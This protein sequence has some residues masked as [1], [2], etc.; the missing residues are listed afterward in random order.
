M[1][2]ETHTRFAKLQRLRELFRAASI[3]RTAIRVAVC[4]DAASQQ[5]AITLLGHPSGT[6]EVVFER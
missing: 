6:R 1:C 3:P 4:L 2:R 5:M